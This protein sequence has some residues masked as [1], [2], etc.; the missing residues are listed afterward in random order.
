VSSDSLALGAE[1]GRIV[2]KTGS[3]GEIFFKVS[4]KIFFK[5]NLAFPRYYKF[6]SNYKQ[7]VFLL[8]SM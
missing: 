2:L 3:H 7:V 4:S 1:I 5:K 6:L 8:T